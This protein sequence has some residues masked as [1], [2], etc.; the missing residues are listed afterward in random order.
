MWYFA[1]ILGLGFAVVLAILN[2]LWLENEEGRR[3]AFGWR[4]RM[5]DGA[6]GNP[7]Q[8]KAPEDGTVTEGNP[9]KM[10]IRRVSLKTMR[11]LNLC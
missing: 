2:A 8:P 6:T 3:E 7:N 1:W 9:T 4:R 10:C 5:A 11:L